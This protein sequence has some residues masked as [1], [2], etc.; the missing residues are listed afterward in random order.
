MKHAEVRKDGAGKG[1]ICWPLGE[2]PQPRRDVEQ[3]TKCYE[4]ASHGEGS[5]VMFGKDLR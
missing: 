1:E 3:S 5:W 4:D 2:M